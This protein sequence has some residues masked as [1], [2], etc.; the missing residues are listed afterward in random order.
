MNDFP[1]LMKTKEQLYE[2]E[3][4]GRRCALKKEM[5]LDEN[6]YLEVVNNE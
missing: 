1:S 6:S 3:E 4:E 2:I 5:R